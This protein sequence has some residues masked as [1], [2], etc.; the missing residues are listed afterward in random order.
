MKLSA[1]GPLLRLME[2]YTSG[3]KRSHHQSDLSFYVWE[4]EAHDD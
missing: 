1:P 3:V 4:T 2:V